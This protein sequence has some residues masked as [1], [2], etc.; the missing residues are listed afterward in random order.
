MSTIIVSRLHTFGKSKAGGNALLWDIIDQGHNSA[1]LFEPVTLP[2]LT[3]TDTLVGNGLVVKTSFH[4]ATMNSVYNTIVGE[5]PP[6]KPC[7]LVF[8]RW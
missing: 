4:W 8:Y 3:R 7:Q 5:E 6:R 2:K 1:G